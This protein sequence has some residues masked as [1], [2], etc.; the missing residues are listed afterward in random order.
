[1]SGVIRNFCQV[2]ALLSR[3]EFA[4]KLDEELTLMI[5][6]LESMP[7]STGKGKITVELEFIAE[8][9]RVDVKASYKTKLPETARFVKTPFWAIGGALSVEH[10]NQIDMFGG[11]RSV[12]GR[13]D[14]H[15]D[16]ES[17]TA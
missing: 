4:A 12:R 7:N 8:L 13:D 10:P 1:M 9:G 2:L 11:P 16:D 3:R 15:D 5:D 14:E 6:T 17:A